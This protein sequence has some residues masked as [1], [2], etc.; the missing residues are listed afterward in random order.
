ML[1]YNGPAGSGGEANVTGW[2]SELFPYLKGEVSP[3]VDI[4]GGIKAQP[5]QQPFWR[6]RTDST[7]PEPCCIALSSFTGSTTSTPFVWNYY[8]V[9]H[10]MEL[11]AGIIGVVAGDSGALK[12]EVGWLVCHA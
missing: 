6:R 9:E 7:E 5:Y 10:K 12:P 2:L 1:K 11:V 8:G 4:P 3:A